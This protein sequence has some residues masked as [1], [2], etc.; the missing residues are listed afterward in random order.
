MGAQGS[1]G[2]VTMVD[3]ARA[4]GVSTTTVSNAFSRPD[5]LSAALREQILD[6]AGRLG[7]AG[8]DPTARSLRSGRSGVLGVVFTERLSWAFAEPS[9]VDFLEGLTRAAETAGTGV[10]LLP[11]AREDADPARRST[12]QLAR[13]VEGAAV[14]GFVVYSIAATDAAGEAVAARRL[15][16]IVVDSPAPA[17]VTVDDEAGARAAMRHVLDLGHRRVGVLSF[18]VLPDGFCGL[19]DA[20]RRRRSPFAVTAARFAGYRG[21]LVEVSRALAGVPDW[22]DVPLH[23]VGNHVGPAAAVGARALLDAHPD[24]TAVVATSDFLALAVLEVARERELRVPEDLSV[25]GFDD[26]AFAAV[27]DP[28]LT[29]VHQPSH[30]KGERAGTALLAWLGG[31]RP[32]RV[33]L[34]TRLVLRASTAPPASG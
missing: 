18:R 29:T 21:A 31:R 15:P 33:V 14:D 3:V 12:E 19:V 5:Q 24:L 17:D 20:D 8:P 6:T 7:Y 2:R 1:S 9:A 10:L 34:P 11:G 32:E 27:S 13:A 25:V 16:A 26:I 28:A 30:E 22:D 23:E 4:L